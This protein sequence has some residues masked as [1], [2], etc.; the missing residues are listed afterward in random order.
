M[1]TLSPKRSV[2]PGA[3]WGEASA[4]GGVMSRTT[5]HHPLGRDATQQ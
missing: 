4:A 2:P 5:R 3:P 1:P